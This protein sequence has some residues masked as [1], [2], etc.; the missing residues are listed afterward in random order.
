MF[1]S[2]KFILFFLFSQ[3]QSSRFCFEKSASHGYPHQHSLRQIHTLLSPKGLSSAARE[4]LRLRGGALLDSLGCFGG[5]AK[6]ENPGD[7]DNL[8]TQAPGHE[9]SAPL[10]AII[11]EGWL[12]KKTHVAWPR[13]RRVY[14]S[15]SSDGFLTYGRSKKKSCV[16]LQEDMIFFVQNEIHIRVSGQGSTAAGFRDTSFSGYAE[17][18]FSASNDGK[19]EDWQTKIEEASFM[20][21]IGGRGRGL[22]DLDVKVC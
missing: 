9:L 21:G 3:C 19:I 12:L 2:S 1:P 20:F 22:R 4:P 16:P 13:W 17:Y 15:I 7:A 6:E 11:K 14:C 5:L 10:Q 18:V 8:Q